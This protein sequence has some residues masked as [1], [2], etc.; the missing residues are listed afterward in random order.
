M[1]LEKLHLEADEEILKTVRRHW[2]SIVTN[3]FFITVVMLMPSIIAACFL[4]FGQS[5]PTSIYTAV[6]IWFHN[7]Q[8]IALYLY[9]AWLLFTL[10]ALANFW[11]DYYLDVWVV[12]NRRVV[13]IDQR[14]FFRRYVSSFRLERLQD[15]NIEIKGILATLLDYGSIEAQTAGNDDDEF[16]GNMLPEPRELKALIV[17]AADKLTN[18]QFEQ[19]NNLKQGL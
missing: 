10:I 7:N 16:V 1:L 13:M 6:T 17:N 3:V 2:W 15:I 8:A 5:L 18:V 14:G 9:S 12:T 11:T 19:I 4:L